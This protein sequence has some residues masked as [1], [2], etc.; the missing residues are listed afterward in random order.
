M[1][2]LHSLPQK[3]THSPPFTTIFTT[4]QRRHGGTVGNE[5]IEYDRW[6]GFTQLA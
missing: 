5:A 3:L 4:E 2:S 1:K 6:A